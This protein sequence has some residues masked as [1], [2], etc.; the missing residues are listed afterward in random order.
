MRAIL[1]FL[2][3]TLVFSS[4]KKKD[5]GFNIFSVQD[6]IELGE[7]LKAEIESNPTDYPILDKATHPKAYAFIEGLMN[8]ILS[9]DLIHY[10]DDFDWEVTIINDDIQ[11]AFAA[12]GGKLYFYTGLLDYIE[13]SAELAGVMAHEVAHSDERHSTEQ[14]SSGKLANLV[15]SILLGGDN[16][17]QLAELVAA[18]ATGAVE[19]RFS[20]EDEYEADAFSVKYLASIASRKNYHPTAIVDF[21][22][23]LIDDGF[24]GDNTSFEFLRTHPYEDNRKINID[25]VWNDLGKPVGEKFEAEYAGFKASYK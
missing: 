25:K 12:P 5:K 18:M 21:F 1:V 11:N 7:Q 23:R 10:R 17:S 4:C 14:M 13:S 20:R 22:D 24:V 2:A 15:T 6:D 9:S 3:F 8:E 19:L 16:S